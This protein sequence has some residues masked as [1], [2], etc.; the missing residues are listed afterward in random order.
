MTYGYYYGG[1]S[2]N[3]G[4]YVMEAEYMEKYNFSKARGDQASGGKLEGCL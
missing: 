4:T 3:D 1:G 2:S